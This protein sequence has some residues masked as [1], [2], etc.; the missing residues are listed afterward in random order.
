MGIATGY[1]DDWTLAGIDINSANSDSSSFTS[2]SIGSFVLYSGSCSG[3]NLQF[4]N[5][6]LCANG[7][8]PNLNCVVTVTCSGNPSQT[9][10]VKLSSYYYSS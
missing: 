9:A 10:N 6:F 5:P 2:C 7:P 3:M 4:C 8:Q 1:D